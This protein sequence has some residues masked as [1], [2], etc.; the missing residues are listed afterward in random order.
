M[1][2]NVFLSKQWSCNSER[3]KVIEGVRAWRVRIKAGGLSH[4]STVTFLLS[5]ISSR[6]F[7]A[8]YFWT[9]L[10][11]K[12]VSWILSGMQ[13]LREKALN[14]WSFLDFSWCCSSKLLYFVC[15]A[16]LL[17]QLPFCKPGGA[18]GLLGYPR[19]C[20]CLSPLST[21]SP[22]SSSQT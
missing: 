5:L 12:V 1:P 22:G 13:L 8:V 16:G 20:L 15:A 2:G 11:W 6:L 14:S 10:L 4:K 3:C 17:Y 19:L 18:L 9:S 7:G 21:S